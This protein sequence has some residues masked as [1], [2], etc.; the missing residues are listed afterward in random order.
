GITGKVR[1]INWAGTTVWEYAVSDASTQMHH[2]VCG[3]PNG[4]VLLICYESKSASPTTVGC[5]STI[6]V[7]SEKI[8]EVQ[9]TGA[10]TG[11]IVW[12]WH[13]WDHLCQSVYPTVT[14]TYVTSVAEHPERMNVNYSI[15]QDWFHMNGIDYNPQLNQ[16]MLSSHANNEIYVIDHRDDQST[17]GGDPGSFVNGSGISLIAL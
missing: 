8:I 17:N 9:P 14:S 7:W 5:A 12:E 15:K 6:T 3:L 13:L 4:N 1:K 2:D 11:T 16:I 10:T